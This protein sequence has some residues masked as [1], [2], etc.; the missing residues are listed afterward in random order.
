MADF[1]ETGKMPAPELLQQARLFHKAG[2]LQQAALAFRQVLESQPGHSESLLKL[3]LIENLLGNRTE[4]LNYLKQAVNQDPN[5]LEAN[6]YLGYI[7]MLSEKYV[8][9]EAVLNQVLIQNPEFAEAFNLMGL[10]LQKSGRREEA[11]EFFYRAVKIRPEYAEASNNLAGVL[12]TLGNTAEAVIYLKKALQFKENFPEALYNLAEIYT[13]QG[14]YQLAAESFKK[15]AELRPGKPEI[16]YKL[17]NVFLTMENFSEAKINYR[18]TLELA[19][20]FGEAH[21]NLGNIYLAEGRLEKAEGYYRQA[22][23][24]MP[25]LA[26][27]HNNLG[28]V[29][30][31]LEKPTEA[32]KAYR[33]AIKLNPGYS[34]AYFNLGIIFLDRGK[35]EE[36]KYFFREA[37]T[38]KPDYPEAYNNLGNVYFCQKDKDQAIINYQKAISLKAD[39]K[40]A[41]YNL[42]G[43]LASQFRIEEAELCF[44]KAIALD[45]KYADA[46]TNLGNIFLAR[47]EIN[48]AIAIYNKSVSLKPEGLTTISNILLALQYKENL[49]QREWKAALD[50]FAEE[51]RKARQKSEP[52]DFPRHPGRKIKIGYSSPDF[53]F[54]SC[55]WYIEPLLASH[56]KEKFAIFCYSDVNDPDQMTA[57]LRDYAD[58]WHETTDY[59]TGELFELIKKDEI[60]L[61]V[62][63]AGHT[64]HNRMPVFALKPAPVQVNWLGFPASTGLDTIDY[65][66]SDKWLNPE[67]SKEYFSEKLW[68]LGDTVHCYRPPDPSPPVAELPFNRNGYIT[69]ASFNNLTKISEF[70]IKLWAAVLQ[71]IPGAKLILKAALSS[72]K[73]VQE[74]L[75]GLFS[76]QGIEPDRIIFTPSF[77]NTFDHLNYYNEADI[78]LDTFPYN[79][80]TTTL[81]SLFMG[82]PVI[83]LTGERAASR[84]GL[85]FLAVTGL[86]ELAA[87]TPEEFVTKTV[88]LANDQERLAGFRNSLRERLLSSVLCNSKSFTTEVEKAFG[89]MWQIFLKK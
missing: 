77:S 44:N 31:S 83:S 67:N 66:F 6:F 65:K 72:S 50:R 42:G 39:F 60:D 46:Y 79:G 54:H 76:T 43:V 13:N 48:E 21:N 35:L 86:G 28:N 84:Y 82:V 88:S 20:G 80:A 87:N 7:L 64:A 26:E 78:S 18:K 53:R 9:A 40:G 73:T 25:G 23:E 1:S 47:G 70:T 85:S 41:L 24:A 37:I 75:T 68:Y 33:E 69:F 5:W 11:K 55:A 74:R 71:Q 59:T 63:L 81:E 19:P 34:E 17:A 12:I 30:S 62:D 32:E 3:G 8:E 38:F 15:L 10:V 56:D 45:P 58:V 14:K 61:L 52:K 4:A 29:L 89:E 57:K 16:Y 49:S 27:V 36:A 2:N 51:C 22:I